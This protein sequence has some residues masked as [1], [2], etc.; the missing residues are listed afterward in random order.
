MGEEVGHR[1][2]VYR[3][4]GGTKVGRE[5]EEQ[6]EQEKAGEQKRCIKRLIVPERKRESES[7]AIISGRQAANCKYLELVTEEAR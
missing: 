3:N 5:E 4:C 1:E 6:E 7:D 2:E